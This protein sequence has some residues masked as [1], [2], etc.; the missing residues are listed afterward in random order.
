MS[1]CNTINYSQVFTHIHCRFSLSSSHSAQTHLFP[2]NSR[3]HGDALTRAKSPISRMHGAFQVNESFLVGSCMLTAG[4]RPLRHP[5]GGFPCFY[6][7]GNIVSVLFWG[8]SGFPQG[9]FMIRLFVFS[10]L[11]NLN[12]SIVYCLWHLSI[13]PHTRVCPDK[14]KC[15]HLQNCLFSIKRKIIVEIFPRPSGRYRLYNTEKV[16]NLPWEGGRLTEMD[17]NLTLSPEMSIT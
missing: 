10:C 16:H 6:Y 13:F 1:A 2:Y 8:Y 14:D 5:G 7:S 17:K 4:G 3:C 9:H 15:F 12:F 11:G